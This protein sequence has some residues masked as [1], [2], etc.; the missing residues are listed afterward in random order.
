MA[1]LQPVP[2]IGGLDPRNAG[3]LESLMPRNGR[4]PILSDQVQSHGEMKRRIEE[5][6][7]LAEFNAAVGTLLDPNQVCAAACSWIEDVVKWEVLAISCTEGE[8]QDF[9]YHV[10]YLDDHLSEICPEFTAGVS[11]ATVIRTGKKKINW[12]ESSN[13]VLSVSFPDKSGVLAVSTS[14]VQESQF[15]DHLLAGIADILSRSLSNAR[16]YAR[17]KTLSMRD[18]LTG[19][20]NRR[21]FEA[22]LEVEG[23]KRTS[24]PFSLMLVDL[25]N[26]KTIND[27]YG[28]AAGDEVLVYVAELLRLNFRKAD[29][30]ARYGGDE[31][32]VLLPDTS[33]D[34]AE[35][36]ADRFRCSVQARPLYLG[37]R[38]I[39]PT[40]SIG[41][42]VVTE[43]VNLK[44]AD[45][46]DEADRA[47]YRA[48]APGKNRV[49]AAVMSSPNG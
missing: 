37:D 7:L 14:S 36:I 28:H 16:E 35:R 4:A 10:L 8:A 23:R 6:S 19:L 40:V 1:M 31:F 48:K 32:A 12:S 24:K 41:I 47:L 5:L 13:N 20:Y 3:R 49:C 34:P 11:A 43:R 38:E 27:T 33:L 9:R 30:P 2:L 22:M 17:L 29:I 21:V 44:L 15:S 26:F 18:H 46:V 25:D 42:A 45:M 39:Q